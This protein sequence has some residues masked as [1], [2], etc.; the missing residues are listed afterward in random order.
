MTYGL[1]AGILVACFTSY[2]ALFAPPRDKSQ[3]PAL[4]CVMLLGYGTIIFFAWMIRACNTYLE[5][6]DVHIIQHAPNKPPLVFAWSDVAE[7]KNNK[8]MQRLE[9]RSRSK[10]PVFMIEHQ[11]ED[12]DALRQIVASRTGISL[13]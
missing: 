8:S 6:T 12:F 11:V 4:L 7:V 13:T 9:L 1:I 5:V 3:F 10:K 2:A